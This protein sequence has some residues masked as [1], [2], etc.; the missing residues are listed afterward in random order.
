MLVFYVIIFSFT[1]SLAS[2]ITATSSQNSTDMATTTS[3]N[4]E[5]SA[6]LSTKTVANVPDGMKL[7]ASSNST[8]LFFNEKTTSF[9]VRDRYNKTWYSSVSDNPQIAKDSGGKYNALFSIS[10]ENQGQVL[11]YDSY[12]NSVQNGDFKVNM[13]DGGVAIDYKIGQKKIITIN[14]LPW[15]VE[16]SRFESLILSKLSAGDKEK[17]LD[18]YTLVSRSTLSADQYNIYLQEYPVLKNADCYI[19]EKGLA[20]YLAQPL[21][22]IIDKTSYTYGDM[23]NDNKANGVAVDPAPLLQFNIK[24]LLTLNNDDL[25]VKVDCSKLK[26]I[27]GY[28]LVKLRF[29]EN[30][31]A[32]DEKTKDGYI[33]I[34]DGSGSKINFS[35][36]KSD[37]P[38]TPLKLYG[39]NYAIRKEQVY[40]NVE[41]AVIPAFGYKSDNG[42]FSAVIEE[43]DAISNINPLLVGP[44]SKYSSVFTSYD[45][46]EIDTVDAGYTNTSEKRFIEKYQET[47]FNS[48]IQV[49]YR[50]LGN[51]KTDCYDMAQAARNMLIENGKLPDKPQI[52]A[53]KDIAFNLELIGSIDKKGTFLGLI[54]VKK[55]VVLTSFK[56]A[57]TILKLLKNSGIG[58]INL[59]YTGWMNGG[60]RQSVV[61]AI[62]PQN[63]LGGSAGFKSLIEWTDKNDISLFPDANLI[64]VHNSNGY[65][66]SQDSVRMLGNTPMNGYLYDMATGNRIKQ[67]LWYVNNKQRT[68]KSFI[69]FFRD[70]EKLGFKNVSFND[71][72]YMLFS[73]FRNKNAVNRE[74]MKESFTNLADRFFTGKSVMVNTGNAY[75]LKYASSISEISLDS[76]GYNREDE[77]VPFV[78]MILHG[79][80][81]YSGASINNSQDYVFSMLRA[82][83]F[84][85]NPS[86]TWIYKNASSI[87]NSD[88]SQY[89]SSNYANWIEFAKTYYIK[90]NNVLS[91]VKDAFLVKHQFITRSLGKSTYSNGVE[92]YVNYGDKSVSIDGITVNAYDFIKRG[93]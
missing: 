54:P 22:A 87:K 20:D 30:F 8:M 10:C 84:G 2:N 67:N 11:A 51:G 62:R 26:Y 37:Y 27:D 57:E 91:P 19:V 46:S 93:D 41:K 80:I 25:V 47:P 44:F 40:G 31:G 65:N 1:N 69:N 43:G 42:A 52:S 32:V 70:Q 7:A 79:Y 14:D 21:K 73:D 3:G 5:S 4:S 55:Q 28:P 61:N 13:I 29:L 59:K 68:E 75:M 92:I 33:V 48:M 72:G 86:F 38:A 45:I 74:E 53:K 23:I 16:K 78:Q 83:D 49:R 88:F 82:V 36:P 56:D 90:A 63:V 76:S 50:F 85:A 58:N 34:P 35:S 81:D 9:A 12:S 18:R 24:I 15:I 71:L 77:V 64:S 6:A 89:F 66:V 39:D 17:V 60:V